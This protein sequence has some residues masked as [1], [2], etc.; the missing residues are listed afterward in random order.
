MEGFSFSTQAFLIDRFHCR[1]A[2]AESHLPKRASHR[3]TSISLNV[4]MYERRDQSPGMPSASSQLL[5]IDSPTEAYQRHSSS[6]L[7]AVFGLELQE[8]SQ[9]MRKYE[10]VPAKS[11]LI[12]WWQ[13]ILAACVNVPGGADSQQSTG[14]Q[15]HLQCMVHGK[16]R[17]LHR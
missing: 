12:C 16:G 9:G 10:V 7:A 8:N 1:P 2:D 11:S 14:L 17:L 4:E 15:G 3:C 5:V 6:R 13:M